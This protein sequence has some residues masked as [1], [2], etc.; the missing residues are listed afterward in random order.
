M[1]V[2]KF[3]NPGAA[4]KMEQGEIINGFT[5]KMWIERYGKEG[6]FTFVAPADSGMKETLPIGS[7]VSHVNSTD[8]M[9]VENH[10]ISDA[11]GTTPPDIKI[12][13]RG[14]ET[15]FDSRVIG[16]NRAFPVS[17]PLVDY[18]LVS[19][20]TWNQIEQLI[21]DHTFTLALVDSDNA[22]PF[23]Q[24][25][26]VVP[27]PPEGATNVERTVKRGSLYAGVLSLLA[28]D[29]SGIKVFRP[30]PWSPLGP[31]S[32]DVAIGIHL[33]V[34]RSD[35]V[36]FSYDT[37]EIISADYLWSNKLFR[38]AILVSGK[39]VEIEVIPVDVEYK[40]RWMYL[41][42]SDIDQ[43]YNVPPTGSDLDAVILQ[44]KLRGT[45]TL[46]SQINTVITKAETA[47]DALKSTY[48]Q[49]FDVG[50]IIMV[51]GDYNQNAKMRISEYVEIED[52]TGE[53]G[54]PT[55]IAYP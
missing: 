43:I 27:S 32:L 18:T 12:T 28:I 21:S 53:S 3:N 22:I 48:R 5:S 51:I 17:E 15:F 40:R 2:F 24:A 47:K 52:T 46:N 45:E 26:A 41:D 49:D 39:W 42:A 20:Y 25:I 34:D 10:E 44:M 30:G 14:F 7:F 33:G 6:E 4:T 31:T 35:T 9:I 50:D 1:D 55:L 16:S 19:D 13:G 36:M 11:A 8:I 29:G 38:N 23:T 54:Y 37:N